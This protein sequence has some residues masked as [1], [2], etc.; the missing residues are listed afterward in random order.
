MRR[1]GVFRTV[2]ASLTL[3]GLLSIAGSPIRAQQQP[4]PA[5]K[6]LLGFTSASADREYALEAQYDALLKA[7]NLKEWLAKLAAR[8][9][10]V[11][12]PYGKADAEFIAGLFK[13]W[14]YETAIEQY[15]VLFPTPTIR[16][17]ELVAPQPQK[18]AAKIVEPPLKEDSTSAQA[19]EQLP[20]YNA[21]SADGDVT[22]EL[23]YVNFGV[24]RDYD[25]LAERG[26]DVK[27]KIV[28]AR[29]GG[30]WRGIK[31]KVAAEHGAIGCLIY[32]DPRDDGYGQGDVYPQ[33][34]W[35]PE[36]GAQRGSV[37]D[38]PVYPGD[39]LTPFIGATKD[40][41][42]L[43]REEAPTLMKIPVMPIAY[44][45]ALPLLKA[46][47]GPVAP[48]AWRGALPITYHL[49]P[50]P[51]K[52]HLKLQ[53]DWKLAPA[54]NVIARMRGA[55]LPDEWIVRGNHHDAWV[56]GAKDPVSGMVAVLEEARAIG[57]LAKTG[58]KPKR[59]L[60]FAG[61]DAEE[62][63][64]LGSTEWVE[65]HADELRKHAVAYINTDSNGR[66]F[67]DAGGSHSLE[68]FI[69]Q[70]VRDVPDPQIAGMS[71]QDRARARVIVR[72]SADDSKEARTRTDLRIDALGS[73]SDYT[74]FLQ[75]L[76]IASLNIGF[77]GEDNGGS[78][79]SI[80]DSIDHYNRFDD[81]GYVYGVALAKAG[82]RA[83]LRLAN[84]DLLPFQFSPLAETI[85]RYLKEVTKL[86]SDLRDQT[87]ET[88]RRIKD[89]TLK[90]V[91]DPKETYVTP[92]PK[93]PVPFLNFTDLQNALD[94]LQQQARVYDDA[95][96]KLIAGGT[97]S[98]DVRQATGALLVQAERALT[99][100]KG[101]PR[102]PWFTH[103]IY[104]P[105]F[106][107]GYG[108][109]TLPGVREA[110]EERQ[111]QEFAQQAAATAEAI[112]RLAAHLQR[113]TAALGA[114]TR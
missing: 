59:T 109:K 102:R 50:G 52:V 25:V 23:V 75:H 65:H 66:G 71:V 49:G 3:T 21:Y 53:F 57:E 29:Y 82:G 113:A 67:W 63:G 86:A 105:G 33:G 80:F 85:D 108:V 40:A 54:Y 14:G 15:D 30:S 74:P 60:I 24:P 99:S 37:L 103:Q 16:V 93:E 72:G 91:A 19:A 96:K 41:K 78:Y 69:N 79:H 89:G 20:V 6:P 36:L 2:T 28:I 10:H 83:M 9:H 51:A 84:A 62:P 31:P 87:T 76:G 26:I 1:F 81:P 100:A 32:S 7:E 35:R 61:W 112:D 42:R 114:G 48:D 47:A 88:N 38:M 77:S 92:A 27:G 73:G 22:A 68:P 45:D 90:A 13:S 46:L 107:T 58:W 55:E 18:L 39:P 12:S 110:I 4:Q 111:W 17:L 64:L 43:T 97:V 8:P 101:L 94:R 70:V 5:A 34:P 56:N 106:Y 44:A 104:A 98:N 11:G 95:Q